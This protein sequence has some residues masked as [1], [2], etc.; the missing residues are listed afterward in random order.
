VQ[1]A[2]TVINYLQGGI[3]AASKLAAGRRL[4]APANVEYLE[5]AS[6]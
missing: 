5:S 4:K 2:L 6:R 3:S 1:D